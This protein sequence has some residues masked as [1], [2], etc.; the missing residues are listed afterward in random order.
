MSKLQ[1]RDFLSVAGAS[2]LCPNLMKDMIKLLGEGLSSAET[3]AAI[4]ASYPQV[5]AQT[6]IDNL[7]ALNRPGVV[8]QLDPIEHPDNTI[9]P[10]QPLHFFWGVHD[11]RFHAGGDKIGNLTGWESAEAALF[12]GD[13]GARFWDGPSRTPLIPAESVP[14]SIYRIGEGAFHQLELRVKQMPSS[15][16]YIRGFVNLR[17][18]GEA[19][20]IW[21]WNEP[22]MARAWKEAFTMGG[23]IRNGAEHE[24]RVVGGIMNQDVNPSHSVSLPTPIRLPAGTPHPTNFEPDQVWNWDNWPWFNQV[25]LITVGYNSRYISYRVTLT[26]T[27]DYDNTYTSISEPCH[28]FVRI[29]DIKQA[30]LFAGLMAQNVAAAAVIAA[31][32]CLPVAGYGW[33]AATWWFGVA[34]TAETVAQFAVSQA[35]DPPELDSAYMDRVPLPQDKG[36]PSTD[37]QVPSLA[38]ILAY[39]NRIMQLPLLLSQIQGKLMGARQA[40]DKAGMELQQG[41]YVKGLQAM[42]SDADAM[43]K[44]LPNFHKDLPGKIQEIDKLQTAAQSLAKGL[45]PDAVMGLDKAGLSK[46]PRIRLEQAITDPSVLKAGLDLSA[47]VDGVASAIAKLTI[48]VREET[49]EVFEPKPPRQKKVK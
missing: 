5:D 35:L 16:T 36:K 18:V 8:F 26:A 48:L 39:A 19:P 31:I 37:G 49:A 24:A 30:A 11:W 14:R 20:P 45:T 40:G 15:P 21:E 22:E 9:H 13:G 38:D 27:D 44:L 23:I 2:L 10:G 34:A 4:T 12:I 29:S 46:E 7:R 6:V 42:I 17:T 1:R 3:V 47:A 43:M 33:V 25:T 28:V 41:T 32:A